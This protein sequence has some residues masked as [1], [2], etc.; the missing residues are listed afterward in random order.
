[1][2]EILLYWFGNLPDSAGVSAEKSALWWKKSS[3]TD[4]TIRARFG[5]AHA[6]AVRGELDDWCRTPRGTLA[7]VILLDQFS[8]NIYRDD[9]RAFSADDKA[10]SIVNQ[11]VDRG[12][13]GK[14]RPIERAF[15]YMPLMHSENRADQDRA[16][17][18]FDAL[19]EESSQEDR[20]AVQAYPKY[21]RA[22]RE[23]V[24][25]FGRFPHRNSVLGRASTPEEVEFL[26]Q[27]GSSF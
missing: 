17:A 25:R 3:E 16:L 6:R 23:I 24:V 13:A 1:M 2:D 15:L 22:H 9:A 26:R 7:L 20:A 11:T 18:L 8:R 4:S 21:A 19:L 10:R 5:D 27:P 12:D 14:L